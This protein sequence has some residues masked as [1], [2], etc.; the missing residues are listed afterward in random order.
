MGNK[1]SK[2]SNDGQGNSDVIY[3]III[4]EIWK[5]A[6]MRNINIILEITNKFTTARVF[7]FRSSQKTNFFFKEQGPENEKKKNCRRI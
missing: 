4:L 1:V 7:Y 6:K 5:I 2:Y 3:S